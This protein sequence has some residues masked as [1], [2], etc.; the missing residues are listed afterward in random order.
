[1]YST[2]ARAARYGIASAPYIKQALKSRKAY[3]KYGAA[4]NEAFHMA[5]N[6]LKKSKRLRRA[7]GRK[8]ARTQKRRATKTTKRMKGELGDPIKTKTECKQVMHLSNGYAAEN[9]RTLYYNQLIKSSQRS[10]LLR[11]ARE[12][13][14]INVR[15]V[16]IEFTISHSKAFP[17]CMNVAVVCPKN[18]ATPTTTGFFRNMIDSV[19]YRATDFSIT[20]N[21]ME[22]HK[23]P[24]N[25]DEYQVYTHKR[26]IMNPAERASPGF[27]TLT[28]FY[29]AARPNWKT[30][31]M[32]IPI[33]R[34][35]T[36]DAGTDEYPN[37]GN[38]WLLYW[39][40]RMGNA[41]SMPVETQVF[42]TQY[43]IVTSFKDMK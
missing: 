6:R 21:Q 24:I 11:N 22:F 7:I 31:S 18:N 36:F 27:P 25:T 5:Y 9:T 32:Y 2:I 4:A 13:D 8:R 29:N 28:E 39:A 30:M 43:K 1:M 35:F 38:L 26:F 15:G 17:L 19:D 3:L 14:V 40:D 23:L 37:N 34:R 42:Y 20:K 16:S 41:G 33:N 12:Q 10:S